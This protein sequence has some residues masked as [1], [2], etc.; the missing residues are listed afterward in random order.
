MPLTEYQ[1]YILRD[2]R[3]EERIYGL[4]FLTLTGS[5]YSAL[6]AYRSQT[7]TEVVTLFSG[8]VYTNPYANR[9]DS[10][11]GFFNVS[12]LIIVAS[13]DHLIKATVKDTKVQHSNTKY[14]I[15]K[16]VDCEDSAEIVLYV[17]QLE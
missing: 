17:S 9:K 14:R 3:S 7:W 12:D 2:I 13:R 4:K 15:N 10:E 11:G 16:V 1:K 6:N 5:G 8:A